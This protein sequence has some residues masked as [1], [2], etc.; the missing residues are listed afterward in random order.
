M[1]YFTDQ[2]QLFVSTHF[3]MYENPFA[4]S[5]DSTETETNNDGKMDVEETSQTNTHAAT[6]TTENTQHTQNTTM[7]G[8]GI[9]I[10]DPSGKQKQNMDRGDSYVLHFY[11]LAARKPHSLYEFVKA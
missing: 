1:I 4:G 5:D 7:G 3:R 2:S 10:Q 11:D 8:S 6:I 9:K